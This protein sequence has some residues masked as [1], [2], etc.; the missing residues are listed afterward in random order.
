MREWFT[1]IYGIHY[2]AHKDLH[3]HSWKAHF[4]QQLFPKDY[5]Q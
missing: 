1:M 5:D 2:A 4:I 3:Y